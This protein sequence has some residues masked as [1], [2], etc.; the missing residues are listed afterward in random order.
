MFQKKFTDNFELKR[1][2]NNI[3]SEGIISYDDL[4]RKLSLDFTINSE[5]EKTLDDMIEN[6]NVF[7]SYKNGKEFFTINSYIGV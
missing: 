6:K 3:I 4:A 7:T 1:K 5:Y 2:I